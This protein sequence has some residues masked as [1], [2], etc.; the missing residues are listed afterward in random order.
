[1]AYLSKL[2]QVN[3]LALARWVCFLFHLK[4]GLVAIV[5]ENADHK[6]CIAW[7]NSVLQSKVWTH[8]VILKIQ[9]NV[10][11][12]YTLKN[13][14]TIWVNYFFKKPEEENSTPNSKTQHMLVF[15]AGNCL[16]HQLIQAPDCLD[17]CVVSLYL[18]RSTHVIEH[19][20][21]ADMLYRKMSVEKIASLVTAHFRYRLST[22]LSTMSDQNSVA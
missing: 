14:D 13:G 11:A 8:N 3:H 16:L 17:R 19:M 4:A 6:L 12:Y 22:T 2:C 5:D 9:W 21:N 1:M 10:L 7:R 20:Y 15:W 18:N